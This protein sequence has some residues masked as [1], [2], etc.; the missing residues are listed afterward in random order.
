MQHPHTIKVLLGFLRYQL[1]NL[2]DFDEFLYR[3]CTELLFRTQPGDTTR[4]TQNVSF[5]INLLNQALVVERSVAPQ[6]LTLTLELIVYLAS[7]KLPPTPPPERLSKPVKFPSVAS[8]PVP[9]P[10]LA[11]LVLAVRDVAL[12]NLRDKSGGGGGGGTSSPTSASSASSSSSLTQVTAMPNLPV[13]SLPAIPVAPPLPNG[14][15]GPPHFLTPSQWSP[16]TQEVAALA[17]AVNAIKGNADSYDSEVRSKILFL[18]EAWVRICN[19]GAKSGAAAMEAHF[20]PYYTVLTQ[21]KILQDEGNLE[22]F[23]RVLMDLC[24]Q[25]C[26]ATAK[27]Y[28]EGGR[29]SVGG[30]LAGVLTPPA[31]LFSAPVPTPKKALTYT[32]VDALAKLVKQLVRWR[33][34]TLEEQLGELGKILSYF[35]RT[36]IRDAD[37][38]GGGCTEALAVAATPPPDSTFDARPYLRLLTNLLPIMRLTPP[39]DAPEGSAPRLEASTYNTRVLAHYANILHLYLL[40]TRVPGFAFAWLELV[41][42]RLFLPELLGVTGQRG[43]VLVQRLL[44]DCLRFLYPYLRRG[45][46]NEGIR[47]FYKGSLRLFL[48]L[49]HDFPDFLADYAWTLLEAIPFTAVHLRSIVLAAG[50]KVLRKF[51]P[52]ADRAIGGVPEALAECALLPRILGSPRDFIPEGVRAEVEG[53]LRTRPPH[54][55]GALPAHP[56]TTVSLLSPS[57]I[58]PLSPACLAT[59]AALRPLLVSDTTEATLTSS[60]WSL[61]TFNA[62]VPYLAQVSLQPCLEPGSVCRVPPTITRALA[63]FSGASELVRGLLMDLDVE[64]RYA[65][66]N[67][68]VS[69]LRYPSAHTLFFMRLLLVLWADTGFPG[70]SIKELVARVLVDRLVTSGPHAW[71]VQVTFAKIYFGNDKDGPGLWNTKFANATQDSQAFYQRFAASCYQFLGGQGAGTATPSQE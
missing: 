53:Y 55:G 54:G 34:N 60:R 3:I 32:G 29:V 47:L 27:D 42:H 46:M 17:A 44:L 13:G 7:R 12:A 10:N 21:Q 5:V 15:G 71:G 45:E 33:G 8:M 26:N 48:L 6:D 28:P 41:S 25:S 49:L 59:V 66:L 20:Q 23:F 52:S 18:L 63:L 35:V 40:P 11:P 58:P 56:P 70:E 4:H 65:L 2:P 14:G 9:P 43:W 61:R 62:L 36:L 50:P 39:P 51:E 22:K 16:N 64:G 19:E 68:L 31:T 67:V 24:V 30:V 69:H 37:I 57:V 1:L 38:N